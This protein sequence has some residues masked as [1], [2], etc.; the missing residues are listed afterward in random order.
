MPV[1]VNAKTLIEPVRRPKEEQRD[2]R[3]SDCSK[4]RKKVQSKGDDLSVARGSD[5]VVTVE[6]RVLYP[7]RE[8][9]KKFRD[10]FE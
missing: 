4:K 10:R 5:R 3:R 7:C 2:S 8:E 9:P 6:A 1:E